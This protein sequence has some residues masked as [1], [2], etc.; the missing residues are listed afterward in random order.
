MRLLLDQGT[1]RSTVAFL[2]KAGFDV[3]HTAD[4]G[5]AEAEDEEILRKAAS[6]D[7]V[8][9]TLDAD[10]HTLLA[11]SHAAKPS[12]VRIRIQGLRAESLSK[13][14]QN[15]LKQC[16]SDL[17]RGA[18]VSVLEYRIRVRRLPVDLK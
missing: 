17:D 5:M 7:R 18:M 13:L 12:V 10:F 3:M 16:Q 9:V 14:L 15:V 11:L 8:I 1:P 6:E 4:L 2:R